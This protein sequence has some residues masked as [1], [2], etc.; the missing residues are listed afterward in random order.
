[1]RCEPRELVLLI[2]QAR[3]VRAVLRGRR[4]QRHVLEK[5]VQRR[6]RVARAQ[7]LVGAARPLR[8]QAERLDRCAYLMAKLSIY[9]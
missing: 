3:P 4:R 5:R 1:M 6:R 7:Q 8:V 9:L 2:K